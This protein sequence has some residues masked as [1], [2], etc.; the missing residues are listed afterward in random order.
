MV[1]I[2]YEPKKKLPTHEAIIPNH[3]E[4]EVNALARAVC[5]TNEDNQNLTPLHKELLR[6]YFRLGHIGLQHVQWLICTWCL[7]VQVNSKAVANHERH[8]CAAWEFV[9]GHC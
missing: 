9:N 3:R 1:Y 6:W 5:V 4:K 2:K 7:K 8:K